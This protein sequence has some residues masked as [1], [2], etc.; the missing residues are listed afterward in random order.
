MKEQIRLNI[1]FNLFQVEKIY[2]CL[3]NERKGI[4]NF[5]KEAKEYAERN[6]KKG[7]YLFKDEKAL[8]EVIKKHLPAELESKGINTW[9]ELMQYLP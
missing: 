9:G 4:T 6:E 7:Y 3:K 1:Y 5:L 2:E 8:W